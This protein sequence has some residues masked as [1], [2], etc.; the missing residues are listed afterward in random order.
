M[1][2]S[3]ILVN[4]NE[5]EGKDS[6]NYTRVMTYEFSAD[7]SSGTVLKYNGIIETKA[8]GEK[9]MIALSKLFWTEYPA[10]GKATY[11]SRLNLIFFHPAYVIVDQLNLATSGSLEGKYIFVR[12]ITL[13]R[14]YLK[15]CSSVLGQSYK[16]GKSYELLI[17]DKLSPDVLINPSGAYEA[18]KKG[19]TTVCKGN[20][21]VV[22]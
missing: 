14:D 17:S 13:L 16:G 11:Y 6:G 15:R 3:I 22:A 9:S 8:N 7:C 5:C 4:L 12:T 2:Q 21:F 20:L 1:I 19:C 18:F 10:G